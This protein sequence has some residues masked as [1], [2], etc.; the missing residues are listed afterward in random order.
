MIM[1]NT[2]GDVSIQHATNLNGRIDV[3]GNDAA[4]TIEITAGGTIT[5]A[6]HL[7]ANQLPGMTD[8][9]GGTIRLCALGDIIMPLNGEIA[10]S[11]G[12]EAP[13]GGGEVDL[14]AG[15]Q[16]RLDDQVILTGSCGGVLMVTSGTSLTTNAV[17]ANATGDGGAG[18]EIDMTSG[19]EVD[20]LGTL[21]ANGGPPLSV[22]GSGGCGGTVCIVAAFGAVNVASPIRTEGATPDGGGGQITILS[23]GSTI[24]QK[25]ATVSARSNGIQGCGGSV[26]LQPNLV[27][28]SASLLDASGGAGGGEVD[29]CAGTDI[30]L[31][32]TIATSTIVDVSGRGPGGAGGGA[33]IQ[34]GAYGQ[35]SVD[36]RSVVD[37]TGGVN[38]PDTGPGNGG[39]TNVG[40]CNVTVQTTGALRA[41]GPGDGGENNL[42]ANEQLTILGKVDAKTSGSGTDGKNTFVFPS[43]KP[44][45][46]SGM[47]TPPAILMPQETCTAALT[48]DCLF[49][50]PACGNGVIEFPEACDDG[51]GLSCH[52]C[53]AFC[54]LENC[55]DGLI[56]TTDS[57]DPTLGCLNTLVTQDPP[58]IEPPTRT[59]TLTATPTVTPTP[60]NTPTPSVTR[61]ITPTP[62]DTPTRTPTPSVTLTATRTNTPTPS[63]T[64]IPTNTPSGTPTFTLTPTPSPT[65]AIPADANCDGRISA[66]D[67]S[68]VV[69]RLGNTPVCG[70]DA[71]LDGRVDAA[72]IDLTILKIFGS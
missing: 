25:N 49:P 59:P 27:A 44:P 68:A 57:C 11:G 1:I 63:A 13:S 31:A 29:V 37:L 66:A 38:S 69:K 52:G 30:I 62:T 60:T 26:A 43:R 17:N 54:Q 53:S 56:C 24:V 22:G 71:N 6:G 65:A 19:T 61:T 14:M 15:G 50:C 12:I 20:L 64:L 21:A 36:I 55:D 70:T 34:G 48:Q 33:N 8:A 39:M 16:V 23:Q 46:V 3:S 7:E 32:A 67:V 41:G 47:V 9:D 18:G 28:N 10:A 5:V 58:C 4:G 51:T 72:D 35:G 40:G 42:T 45:V 2:T